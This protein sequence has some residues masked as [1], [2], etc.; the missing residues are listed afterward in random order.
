MLKSYLDKVSAPEF[1][2]LGITPSMG[3]VLRVVYHHEGASMK[4]VSEHL[5]IDKAMI[6]RVVIK[7]IDMGLIE[8]NAKGHAYS[9]RLTEQ[10]IKAAERSKEIMDAAWESLLSDLTE[11][12]RETFDRIMGKISDKVRREMS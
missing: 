11:E 6:T 2:L 4:D 10:G 8:N 3:M 9:L 1:E 5:R 12:E 7:L